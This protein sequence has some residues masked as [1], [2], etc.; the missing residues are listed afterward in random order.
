MEARRHV[1]VDHGYAIRRLN[2]AYF[3]FYGAYADT[4]GERG[5]DPVGP[6]VEAFFAKCPDVGA[7]IRAIAA[8]TSFAQLQEMIRTPGSCR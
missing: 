1:F 3:A 7:F 6:A 8:V 4:P 2:Q 5:E